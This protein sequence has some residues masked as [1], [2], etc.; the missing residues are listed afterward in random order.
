MHKV[1]FLI[2]AMLSV[3]LTVSATGVASTE[4]DEPPAEHAIPDHAEA[5]VDEAEAAAES[6]PAV[7]GPDLQRTQLEKY[8][9]GLIAT[10]QREH[11]LAAVTVSV[12]RDDV[13]WLAAGYGLADIESAREVSPERIRFRIG[14][15]SKTFTWTAVMMLAERGLI[16]LD[17]D[18]NDY[19]DQFSIREAFGEPVT[20]RQVMHHRAGFEDTLR[21]F[22]VADDEPRPLA[23]LLAEHQPDRVFPPGKR[24]SYSN[25]ASALA[26]QVVE[27]VT[28]IPYGEFL[29]AELL[30][31]L[32]MRDTD[33]LAPG[34]MSTGQRERLATGY[35]PRQGALDLQGFMQIGPYWPAGGMASTATDM[36]RWMRFH[37]NGGELDGVRLM[38]AETHAEMW[39][40][41]Y[42]DRPDAADVAHGFQDR[43]YRG[44][45]TFGHGGGTA[46]Y[47]TNMVLVP[48]LSLG[49]FLSQNST[50]TLSPIRQVPDLIIDHVGGFEYRPWALH[51]DA[52]GA[53]ALGELAGTY[54]NNRRVFSTFSAVLGLF[55]T[56]RVTPVS[57]DSLAVTVAGETQYMRPISEDVFQ[58]ASG[59][60]IAFL[61]DEHGRV[62]ALA[63]GMGVHSYERVGGLNH[64]NALMFALG[65]ALVLMLSHAVGFSRRVG[66]SVYTGF[67][68]RMAGGAAL[69]GVLA[70]FVLFAAIIYLAV[71]MG[72]FDLSRMP[73]LYPP[74][75]MF[76][77][78][79]AGWVVAAAALVTVLAQWP[80]W[81]G[82][83]WGLF[84][85]L[86]FAL[87]ALA[88]V[89]LS[90][91]LWQWRIIG[92][93]VM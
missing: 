74:T 43:P 58:S 3:G 64:P 82:S 47:L 93:Q 84:K 22:A 55:N 86:H 1:Q 13:L 44:L 18:I 68:A 42:P 54:L 78:H 5:Q 29:Q 70:V 61:R 72:E 27:N 80:A 56:A 92:A 81:S 67:A 4:V 32:A 77:V 19:L 28:G 15:V 24:T 17:A 51:E 91:Q 83:G 87:F 62:V 45:R 48:E 76:L 63:D 89:F 59:D 69:I 10:Q 88:L 85:R 90:V 21:L 52:E 79:Y 50:H 38:R 34:A 41:A 36:A 26:A 60:R 12:V 31:P 75:A 11:G 2:V 16:D 65:G 37:L 73:E 23:E 7:A 39:T 25:W 33:W 66:R 40:R 53:E 35:R 30:D 8:L 20:M 6:D 57:A 49:I 46:A 14:S 9:D 71:G